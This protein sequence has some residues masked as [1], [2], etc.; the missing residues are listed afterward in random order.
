MSK[1]K[2]QVIGNL[3]SKINSIKRLEEVLARANAVYDKHID[4]NPQMYKEDQR[5]Y[6]VQGWLETAYETLYTKLRRKEQ[7]YGKNNL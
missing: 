3:N 4:E 2:D 7:E 5:V 1:T 6:F